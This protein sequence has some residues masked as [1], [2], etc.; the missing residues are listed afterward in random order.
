[1]DF[2]GVLRTYVHRNPLPGHIS[3]AALFIL[4]QESARKRGT[5]WLKSKIENAKKSLFEIPEIPV[6]SVKNLKRRN[7]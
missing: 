6:F 5:L 2:D 3:A 1:M 7:L 4:N